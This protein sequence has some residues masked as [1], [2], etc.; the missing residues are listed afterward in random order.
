MFG[1]AAG[2]D[3]FEL[4]VSCFW[5]DGVCQII[6]NI[7]IMRDQHPI[8]DFDVK[9]GPDIALLSDIAIIPNRYFPPVPKRQEFAFHMGKGSDRDGFP[10][11]PVVDDSRGVV[12][13]R[14]LVDL[15]AWSYPQH[16]FYAGDHFTI[17]RQTT[18]RENAT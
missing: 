18:A 15:A 14:G 13:D 6:K 12:Q 17:S 9:S 1:M 7:H 11:I 8:P 10:G 5:I 3:L 4:L 2:Y 16:P